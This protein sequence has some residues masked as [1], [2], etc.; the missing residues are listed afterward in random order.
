VATFVLC[1]RH[2]PS[3]CRIAFA[4]WRGFPSPLRAE[5]ALSSC[6]VGGHQLWWFVEAADADGALA[7][8]PAYVATRTSAAE[9]VL[10]HLP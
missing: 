9:V 3:E 1:H 8:L 7:M 5:P 6:T 2:E 10:Q 4:A